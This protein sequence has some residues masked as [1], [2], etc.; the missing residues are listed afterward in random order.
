MGKKSLSL[1][2][3]YWC[4]LT[5]V[6]L[7]PKTARIFLSIQAR[8]NLEQ[9]LSVVNQLQQTLD[10]LDSDLSS[11]TSSAVPRRL[12]DRDA[13]LSAPAV[14]GNDSN[15]WGP[16]SDSRYVASLMV[17]GV[18]DLIV[19][20]ISDGFWNTSPVVNYFSSY[21]W[22]LFPLPNLILL[23]FRRWKNWSNVPLIWY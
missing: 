16:A 1:V 5:A 6:L 12:H 20:L 18:V 22:P 15:V 17:I 10:S 21:W 7:L 23:C 13:S 11:G 9:E 3:W 8:E 14:T 2:N 19:C 4:G